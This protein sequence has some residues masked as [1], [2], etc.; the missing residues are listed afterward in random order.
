MK[1]EFTKRDSLR[2]FGDTQNRKH[3]FP[4]RDNIGSNIV[5]EVQKIS[6]HESRAHLKFNTLQRTRELWAMARNGWPFTR[7]TRLHGTSFNLMTFY[8]TQVTFSIYFFSLNKRKVVYWKGA[9]HLVTKEMQ[10]NPR[11]L[12]LSGKLSLVMVPE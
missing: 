7:V 12:S 8:P 6:V 3:I 2:L 11:E 9:N 5:L 4:S 1:P 10:L